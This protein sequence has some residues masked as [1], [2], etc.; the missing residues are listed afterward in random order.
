MSPPPI[1]YVTI[2]STPEPMRSLSHTARQIIRLKPFSDQLQQETREQERPAEAFGRPRE[3]P[4][5]SR[6][7]PPRRDERDGITGHDPPQKDG[8]D[9]V[10]DQASRDEATCEHGGN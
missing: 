7:R 4:P 1:T 3:C 6:R 5:R 2:L 10:E 9:H 8:G